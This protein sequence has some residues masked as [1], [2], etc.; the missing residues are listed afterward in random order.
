M[1]YLDFIKNRQQQSPAEQPQKQE[2][3]K[4]MYTRQAGQEQ[5]SS[6]QQLANA[7]KAQAKELGARIDKAAG[8]GHPDAPTQTQAP[9]DSTSSP[10]PMRQNMTRQDHAAPAMSPTSAQ[11]GSTAQE[12]ETSQPSRSQTGEQPEQ[13]PQTIA[14]PTPSWER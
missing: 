8:Q 4:E 14:R 1:G 2:T 10:E 12:H 9:T 6:V 3:A 11:R 7:D 13:R 5:T